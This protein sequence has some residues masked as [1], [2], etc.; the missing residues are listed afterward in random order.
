MKYRGREADA[1]EGE[2]KGGE[3]KQQKLSLL[4]LAD[5]QTNLSWIFNSSNSLYMIRPFSLI[6]KSLYVYY[7]QT[8]C[9]RDEKMTDLGAICAHRAATCIYKFHQRINL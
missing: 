1:G 4:H 8:M 9:R 3:S 6:S 5:V 2:S 7:H